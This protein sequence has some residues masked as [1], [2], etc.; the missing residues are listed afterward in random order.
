MIYKQNIFEPWPI[1]SET[2]QAVITS[3]PYFGLTINNMV[4]YCLY[5]KD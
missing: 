2:V 5:G 3:P 4:V 1:E